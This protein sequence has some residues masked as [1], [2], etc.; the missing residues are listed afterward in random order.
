MKFYFDNVGILSNVT[1]DCNGLS[2]ITG[3]NNS[4]KTTLGKAIYALFDAVEDLEVKK[5]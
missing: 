2:V 5:S 4:G 3:F 1:I